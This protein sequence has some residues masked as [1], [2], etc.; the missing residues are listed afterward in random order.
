LPARHTRLALPAALASLAAAC[1]PGTAAAAAP[2]KPAEPHLLRADVQIKKFVV[3]KA[4]LGAL[5][6]ASAQLA[7]ADARKEVRFSVTNGATC[8]IL[9]LDLQ[10]LH[11]QLLGLDLVTS[12]INLR[13]TGNT[14]RT[15]GELFCKLATGLKL[16]K[17]LTA[18]KAAAS[19]N[20]YMRGHPMHAVRVR[21]RLPVVTADAAQAAPGCKVLDLVLGPLNLDLLGLV[22]DLYGAD[23]AQ[24]VEVHVSADP[25]GGVLGSVFCK[26]A[27][28]QAVG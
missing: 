19:L 3:T 2:A 7:G 17:A 15:L 26:L 22:V 27:A 28:G 1:A 18:R 6:T 10:Q 20:R 23:K 11:L 4:G 13:I 14:S 8:S 9:T 24:P 25:A 16:S 5:G 21:S 12:A